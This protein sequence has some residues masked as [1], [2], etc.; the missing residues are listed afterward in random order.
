MIILLFD[1]HLLLGSPDCLGANIHRRCLLVLP[2]AFFLILWFAQF[3]E[4][5]FLIIAA[6]L[7]RFE[8]LE[9]LLGDR[10]LILARGVL[11]LDH[12]RCV[13]GDEGLLYHFFLLSFTRSI[14]T[15]LSGPPLSDPSLS[16][17]SL[18]AWSVADSSLSGPS[19]SPL[20]QTIGPLSCHNHSLRH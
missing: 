10:A 8:Q 2:T 16:D 7:A 19:W 11:V 13:L 18:S 17:P 20:V 14:N 15:S 5:L 12:V 3:Q 9:L 1:L 4:L 6:D